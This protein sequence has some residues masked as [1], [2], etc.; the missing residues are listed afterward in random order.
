MPERWFHDGYTAKCAYWGSG[1]S[2]QYLDVL[3]R[4]RNKFRSWYD[5]TLMEND[6]NLTI[7]EKIE[8]LVEQDS[9]KASE[10]FVDQITSIGGWSRIDRTE[11]EF[12][13]EIKRVVDKLSE[14]VKPSLLELNR[15]RYEVICRRSSAM[16]QKRAREIEEPTSIP[17]RIDQTF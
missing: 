7:N 10:L 1:G 3:E 8:K 11:P 14:M 13:D 9:R 17:G 15:K 2:G 16:I 4:S 6:H 12:R 5:S